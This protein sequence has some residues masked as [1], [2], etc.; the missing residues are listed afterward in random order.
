[1]AGI[2]NSG[3]SALNAFKRQLETT[4]HNIAN[5]NTEGY[6]RQVVQFQTRAPQA[7]PQGF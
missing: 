1:M 2:I 7:L 3:I 6:S 5:V 4:G